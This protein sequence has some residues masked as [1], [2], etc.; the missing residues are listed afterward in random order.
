M[1]QTRSSPPRRGHR[2]GDAVRARDRLLMRLARWNHDGTY[3]TKV[4]IVIAASIA[5][6]A[7]LILVPFPATSGI[8]MTIPAIGTVYGIAIG[9]GVLEMYDGG[10]F[11]IVLHANPGAVWQVAITP[12]NG[13]P[14]FVWSSNHTTQSDTV[15]L[16]KGDYTVC[17]ESNSPSMHYLNATFTGAYVRNLVGWI[18][19][20]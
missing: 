3:P 17:W 7:L 15:V 14:R 4:G 5:A 11:L 10:Q 1:K 6:V 8:R 9:C 2:G 16:A 13:G 20:S 19:A 18:W 12:S